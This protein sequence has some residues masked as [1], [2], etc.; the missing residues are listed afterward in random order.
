LVN[1]ISY[2]LEEK[3]KNS[4]LDLIKKLYLNYKGIEEY[5]G[6]I[7]KILNEKN[8]FFRQNKVFSFIAFENEIPVG[9]ISA[10]LDERLK[11]KKRGIIGFFECEEN[12]EVFKKLL[13]KAIEKLKSE[14][15][16]FMVGPINLTIWHSYRFTLNQE[17]GSNFYFEPL[18]KKYYD[19]FFQEEGF[20]IQEEYYSAE[21]NNFDAIIEMTQKPYD[22]LLEKGYKIRHLD[23]NNIEKEL[24][25]IYN[26]SKEI[27]EG[28]ENYVKISEEE[29]KFIYSDLK[30]K[31]LPE[32]IEL[33]VNPLGRN[34]GFCFTIP[35][36]LNHGTLIMK[37]IAVENAERKRGLGAAILHSQH[38]RIKN[39]GFNKFIYALI[40][41][42]N[43]IEKL[44]YPDANIIREYRTYIKPI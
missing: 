1:I 31:I 29:F 3:Y 14:G 21:R 42:K 35:D 12:K 36:P 11:H 5:V 30:T 2:S 20:E 34:V 4:Y 26:L 22:E 23:L 38:I 37:T 28:S 7:N 13:D 39:L 24:S 8:P 10:I 43:T 9:H 19:D 15:C 41:K 16:E 44:P 40:R 25:T 33:F 32:F 6:D 17:P 18:S 27:F